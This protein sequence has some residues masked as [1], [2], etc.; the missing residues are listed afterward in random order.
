MFPY[1]V[2][3]NN[4]H[5]HID[6]YYQLKYYVFTLLLKILNRVTKPQA[7]IIKEMLKNTF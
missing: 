7:F 1:F 2:N 6:N 4:Y 5:L 3:S